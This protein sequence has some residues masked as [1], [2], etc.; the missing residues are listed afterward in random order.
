VQKQDAPDAKKNLLEVQ[1]GFTDRKE[2]FR[3]EFDTTIPLN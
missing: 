2:E 1:G 3:D